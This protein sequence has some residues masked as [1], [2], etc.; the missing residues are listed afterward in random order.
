MQLPDWTSL[1]TLEPM[2]LSRRLQEWLDELMKG[3]YGS[4]EEDQILGELPEPLQAVWVLNWMD[5]EVTMGSL[6]AY[7]GNGQRRHVDAA[8]R[9][10]RTIGAT[11]MASV[12]ERATAVYDTNADAW[13]ERD[14]ELNQLD[15]YSIVQPYKELPGVEQLSELTD[16]YYQMEKEESWRRRLAD[17]VQ[18]S[19]AELAGGG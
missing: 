15:E 11:G 18:R 6:L 1:T 16:A 7:F 9:G 10:L 19:V 3:K 4:K 14:K 12:L 17:Y 8:I 13:S 5:F 2:E